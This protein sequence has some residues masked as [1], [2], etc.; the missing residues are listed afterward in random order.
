M[1]MSLVRLKSEKGCAGDARQKLKTT[2][3]TSVREGAPH[4][5]TRNCLKINEKRKWE[6][7]VAGPRWVPDTKTNWLT[8]CRSQYN[9]DFDFFGSQ[10]VTGENS[11]QN[12]RRLKEEILE[13]VSMSAPLVKN[14]CGCG[15]GTV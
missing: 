11:M 5:Q 8:N 15:A 7:L 12:S 14:C 6:K 3:P 9:F 2:Y 4:Q 10:S 13:G 1:L